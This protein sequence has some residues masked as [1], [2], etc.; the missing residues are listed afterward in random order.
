MKAIVYQK[1]GPPE[2]LQLQDVEKPVPKDNEILVR[3]FATP[4]NFGDLIARNFKNVP[5]R[6]FSM[7]AL[8]WLPTKILLGFDKPKRKIL[9]SEFAGEVA[10]VGKDV[11]LFKV[12]DPVFGYRSMNFGAYAEYVCMPE[13]GLV[14][15]KP[16]NMSFD[17]AAAVPYGALTA[18]NLL[19][20][21]NIHSGYNVLIFMDNR[22][23]RASC[24]EED[25]G[26]KCK[27]SSGLACCLNL[28]C[29]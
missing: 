16:V 20:K 3:V 10:E 7:P 26:G 5:P 12:G 1:Y 15:H 28:I 24:L 14:T 25:D 6:S 17:E 18:L 11:N 9:G 21:V 29:W 19:R 22:R 27:Q 23:T 2:V 13:K 4:V 8:L